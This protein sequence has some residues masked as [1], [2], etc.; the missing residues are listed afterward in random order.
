LYRIYAFFCFGDRF[1]EAVQSEILQSLRS[2][3]MTRSER[4]RMAKSEGLAMKGKK[5]NLLS[6]RDARDREIDFTGMLGEKLIGFLLRQ[7]LFFR[8]SSVAALPQNDKT[9]ALDLSRGLGRG[10][11]SARSMTPACRDKSGR[12]LINGVGINTYFGSVNLLDIRRCEY[13]EWRAF[14][15]NFPSI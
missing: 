13:V 5:I 15:V 4:F 7:S 14:S 8:D 3:R 6:L 11:M 12:Q 1:A 9:K 2:F 10:I